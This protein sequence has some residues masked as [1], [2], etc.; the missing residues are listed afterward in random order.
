MLYYIARFPLWLIVVL[1][2]YP[3]A[4]IAVALFSSEDKLSLTSWKWLETIDND[5]TGD[6]GHKTEHQWGSDSLAWYNRIWWLW[7][8]GGNRY[9]YETIG[10]R[11]YNT[12][13]WAFEYRYKLPIRGTLFF[14][15]RAGWAL[16]GPQKGLCKYVFNPRFK[17]KP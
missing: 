9:C 13:S 7:R 16:T 14:E 12:P 15:F 1:A 3:C 10:V 6:Y 4:V 8:N 5:L 11:Y 17:T 2:R